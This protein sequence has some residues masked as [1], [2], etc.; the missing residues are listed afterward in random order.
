MQINNKIILLLT[1]AFVSFSCGA[2]FSATTLLAPENGAVFDTTTPTLEW[3]D[4]GATRYRLVVSKDKLF[5]DLDDTE[6][7]ETACKE[8]TTCQTIRTSYT[9]YKIGSDQIYAG[10][11]IH[12]DA[13]KTY[14]WKIRDTDSTEW[15][16]VF[17][18]TISL[19]KPTLT[20]PANA[21]EACFSNCAEF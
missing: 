1:V 8:N 13:G 14:Y 5:R 21:A 19:S 7:I 3:S 9:N 18:F 16:S 2:S 6:D 11:P 10:E 4:V 15:S 12:L 20:N 17:N